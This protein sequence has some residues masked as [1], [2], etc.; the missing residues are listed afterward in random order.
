MS[1]VSPRYTL[2]GVW[3]NVS[4]IDGPRPPARTAPSI[5]YEEVETPNRN[6]AGNEA[7]MLASR[8][9]A[10]PLAMARTTAPR[11][12]ASPPTLWFPARAGKGPRAAR[13]GN[14]PSRPAALTRVSAHGNPGIQVAYAAGAELAGG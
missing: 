9:A 2:P 13:P 14:G 1:P 8:F 11:P 12:G 10:L 4:Q 3:Q 6:P 5:W 7:G